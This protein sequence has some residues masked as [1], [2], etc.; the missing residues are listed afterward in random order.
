MDTDRNKNINNGSKFKKNHLKSYLNESISWKQ[1]IN[2]PSVNKK[3][4]YEIDD[5]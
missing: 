3:L 5:D 4:Q 1:K 2:V